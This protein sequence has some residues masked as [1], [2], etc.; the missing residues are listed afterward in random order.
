MVVSCVYV[1]AL[2]RGEYRGLSKGDDQRSYIGLT[3]GPWL[4]KG[5]GTFL[6]LSEIRDRK[7]DRKSLHLRTVNSL[8]RPCIYF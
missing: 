8:S 1:C 5:L 7:M 4:V 3:H 2:Y 6:G